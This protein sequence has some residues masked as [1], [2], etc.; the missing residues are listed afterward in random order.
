VVEGH[1]QPFP[2]TERNKQTTFDHYF[3]VTSILRDGGVASMTRPAPLSADDLRATLE[4]LGRHEKVRAKRMSV[5][6]IS[7]DGRFVVL[8]GDGTV[9]IIDKGKDPAD[10]HPLEWGLR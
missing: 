5:F 10:D 7:C 3:A 1:R 2:D 6:T 9:E 8:R 4:E